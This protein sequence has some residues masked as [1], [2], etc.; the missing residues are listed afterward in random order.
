MLSRPGGRAEPIMHFLFKRRDNFRGL[1][2]HT[3]VAR[4]D[5]PR[6][7]RGTEAEQRVV[8]VGLR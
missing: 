8:I 2:R 1:R 5:D 6:V 7:E 4:F 3:L